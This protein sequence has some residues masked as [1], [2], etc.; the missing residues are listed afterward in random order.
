MSRGRRRGT[1][2]SPGTK[3]LIAARTREGIA[4]TRTVR[5][6]HC[7]GLLDRYTLR[8]LPTATPPTATP[9]TQKTSTTKI[10]TVKFVVRPTQDTPDRATPVPTDNRSYALYRVRTMEGKAVRVGEFEP[11]KSMAQALLAKHSYHEDGDM[12]VQVHWFSKW[13]PS[14]VEYPAYLTHIVME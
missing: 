10:K 1:R 2:L 6:P 11:T 14:S 12:D 7:N 9:S 4:K 3:L 13:A 8:T 5:C